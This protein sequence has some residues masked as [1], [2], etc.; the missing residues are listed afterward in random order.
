MTDTS[1]HKRTKKASS[2]TFVAEFPLRTS[3]AASRALSVRLDAAR[4]IYNAAI[5]EGL[6][7]LDLMRESKAWQA[8]RK[9]PR[10]I[11]GE[12]NKARVKAFRDLRK[13]FGFSWISLKTLTQDCRNDCWI[14]DHLNSQECQATTKRA[15]SAVEQYMYGARGRPRFRGHGYLNSFE[16]QCNTTGLCFK[17]GFVQLSAKGP[18]I[19]PILDPRD[20]DGYQ[21]EA[22]SRRVKRCRIV[23]RELNGKTRWYV[24]L[25]LEGLPPQRRLVSDGHVG[26]DIGP[27]TIAAVS[28][29]GA[30]FENFCPSIAQPWK[31]LRRIERAMDRSRRATNPDM[32][33][34][35]G[36]AKKRKP[37]VRINRSRRYQ[38]LALKRRERERRL[39]SER[40]RAHGELANRVLGHGVTVHT[41]KLSYKGWQRSRFGKSMKV[42]APGAFVEILRRKTKAAG[43]ELIEIGTR[44]TKLS[45]FDH[46]TGEYVK[47]PLSQRKHVFGDGV[48]A[49]VHRDLYS[50]FL[51]RCCDPEA[52]DMSQVQEAWPGAEPLLR[53]AMFSESESASVGFGLPRA[54]RCVRADRPSKVGGDDEATDVV[55]NGQPLA[56]AVENLTISTTKTTHYAGETKKQ[57]HG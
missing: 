48:T 15:F 6:R 36:T 50:A 44:H 19:K 22:L 28:D 40:K 9:L 30:T 45:Q 56:R 13:A 39:A 25:I 29:H 55:T 42:R 11:D 52:L 49:P 8:A 53:R 23:R 10:T 20:A 38:V 26:L 46:T 41:E 7:R 2:E 12:P 17:N 1:K 21:K 34:E 32:Y 3:K 51:A 47:K 54:L 35:D 5:G 57:P 33:N 4:N 24:Q 16:N 31:E 18:F 37:G 43:G 27:S 14:K